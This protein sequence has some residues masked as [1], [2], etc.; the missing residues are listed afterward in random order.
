M[1]Y[2]MH[3]YSYVFVSYVKGSSVVAYHSGLLQVG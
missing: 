2:L 1:K 3:D